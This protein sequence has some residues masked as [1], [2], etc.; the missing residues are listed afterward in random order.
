MTTTSRM[1]PL[2]SACQFDFSDPI[3]L[4]TCLITWSSSSSTPTSEPSRYPRHR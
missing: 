3:W 1:V 4:M 2:T